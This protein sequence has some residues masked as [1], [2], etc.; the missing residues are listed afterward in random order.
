MKKRLLL[1]LLVT[2]MPVCAQAEVY[3]DSGSSEIA[4]QAQSVLEEL[5]ASLVQ[6]V[7]KNPLLLIFVNGH[8]DNRGSYDENKRLSLSRAAE[9]R[10]YLQHAFG[11]ASERFRITGVGPDEPIADNATADGRK[12]NRRVEVIFVD[13]K[14]ILSEDTANKDTLLYPPS[15][16]WVANNGAAFPGESFTV[17]WTG[18]SSNDFLVQVSSS[19]HFTT[20]VLSSPTD[21]RSL[22]VSIATGSYWVR[23]ACRNANR[24]RSRFCQPAQVTL[25]RQQVIRS[26]NLD[27]APRGGAVILRSPYIVTGTVM[28]G[29]RVQINGV[30]VPVGDDQCFTYAVPLDQGEN[31]VVVR[32]SLPGSARVEQKSYTVH[33]GAVRLGC[34][35]QSGFGVLQ[36][37]VNDSYHKATFTGQFGLSVKSM[38]RVDMS[39]SGAFYRLGPVYASSKLKSVTFGALL[40]VSYRLTDGRKPLAPYIGAKLALIDLPDLAHHDGTVTPWP[41]LSCGARYPLS[42]TLNFIVNLDCFYRAPSDTWT[43]L[44]AGVEIF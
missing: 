43:M 2:L 39:L 27:E 13:N 41:G 1:F 6:A 28:P 36:G 10:N 17:L 23:V 21:A 37:D 11:I 40:G 26:V 38:Y 16:V 7:Q 35:L 33:C 20:V 15:K 25:S 22:E 14:V 12:R 24:T 44:N 18:G 8:T 29:A 9:V 19:I 31:T 3:F 42:E 5:G 4:P 32:G 34:L 30:P